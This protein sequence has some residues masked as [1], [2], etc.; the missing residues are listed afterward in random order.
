M[1]LSR[2]APLAVAAAA[3][4]AAAA[5]ALAVT[6]RAVVLARAGRRVLG[7]LDQLLR[8][9]SAPVLVLLDELQPDPSTR[10]VDLLH[11]H[12]QDVTTLDHVLDVP[13]ASG[14]DVRPVQQ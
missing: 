5:A 9:D 8:T 1:F 10:L 6:R 7:A 14:S 3:S 4:A 11:D 12:V 2:S 13:D